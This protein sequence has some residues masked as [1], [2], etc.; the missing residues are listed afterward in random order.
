MPTVSFHTFGC[1][2]NQ[3]ETSTLVEE[4]LSH[5]YTP[6]PFP[7]RSDVFVLNTCAVTGRSESKCRRLL[8]RVIRDH[9]DMTIIVVGCVPQVAKE[10]LSGIGGIDY[11][12]GTQEKYDLF[13][14]FN[15][16]GKNPRPCIAVHSVEH[17]HQALSTPG[18]SLDHSRAFLK[19]QDGCN[20]RC[21]YCVVPLARGPSRSIPLQTVMQYAK[22]LIRRGHQ[23]IVITGVHIGKYGVDLPA[24]V[25]LAAL[26]HN[27]LTL[28]E[29]IRL[30]LSSLDPGDIAGELI[31]CVSESLQI[32]RH[33]HIPMQSGSNA[34]LKAMRR[35]YTAEKYQIQIE[36]IMSA[37]PGAG[38][39]TDVIVG[40]PGETDAQF[41]ET[42]RL[43]EQLPFTYIHVF[44]FSPRN[45]TEAAEMTAVDPRVRMERARLIRELGTQKR[46]CFYGDQL[47]CTKQV[48]FESRD[49]SGWMSGY[50]SEYVRVEAV[51][52]NSLTN[53]I[54]PVRIDEVLSQSVRGKVQD[55]SVQESS[56]L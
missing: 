40:F 24:G 9:P 39:G 44:P 56:S 38:L 20:E 31:E 48:L 3:A 19:I 46:S 34:I 35:R 53:R 1:K 18:I 17:N 22:E 29:G 12:L 5:G 55:L 28:G 37:V 33:F 7:E 41:L 36:K 10:N 14:Y 13:T 15:G 26:L 42:V 11:I 21:A 25:S 52:D 16:P 49:R 54:V 47:G 51:Y 8:R 23:E 30:R 50:T 43:I 4:F 32:C 2:L 45:H 6:I 27:L